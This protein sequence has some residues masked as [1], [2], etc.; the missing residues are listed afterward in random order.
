GVARPLSLQ[1]VGPGRYR[2]EFMIDDPGAYLVNVHYRGQQ[3][4]EMQTGYVQAA[5]TVP[6]AREYRAVRDNAALLRQ[7]RDETSGQEFFL[8]DEPTLINLFDREDLVVPR[9][10]KDVWDLMIILAASLFVLDVAVRRLSI[11]RHAVAARFR[12]LVGREDEIGSDTVSAFKRARAQAGT[13]RDPRESKVRFEA[14]EDGAGPSLDVGADAAHDPAK[15]KVTAQ[16]QQPKQQADDEAESAMS[17]L[18]AAK[19]RAAQD[20]ERDQ[21]AGDGHG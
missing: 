11:D 20:Q 1:Q 8:S 2:G 19:R 14:P 18:R 6:Y 10:L 12:R 3:E 17:R 9:T 4:G 13:K 7:L 16:R 15:T 5:V 21:D